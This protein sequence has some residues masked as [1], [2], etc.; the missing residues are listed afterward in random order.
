MN[1]VPQL[2]DQDC[3]E[4]VHHTVS[5]PSFVCSMLCPIPCQL[6]IAIRPAPFLFAQPQ[7]GRSRQFVR[8]ITHTDW[9]ANELRQ[10]EARKI[11][12]PS[13]SLSFWIFLS[14]HQSLPT[15]YAGRVTKDHSGVCG[16][17]MADLSDEE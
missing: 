3:I 8:H 2:L 10:T 6:V 4:Q 12:M 15:C 7:A 16:G 14:N 17:D 9:L 1:G 11:F 13:G 5:L